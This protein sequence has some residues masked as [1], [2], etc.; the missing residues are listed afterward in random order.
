MRYAPRVRSHCLLSLGLLACSAPSA[1]ERPP[2][3]PAPEVTVAPT[4]ESL[5]VAAPDRPDVQLDY[6]FEIED[7]AAWAQLAARSREH[8][9]AR[10]DVVKVLWDHT[11]DRLWFCQSERWPIHYD[12]AV[13][14]IQTDERPLGD[15]SSFNRAQYLR[16]DRE[17]Q[18]ASLVRYRDAE[19]W[20]LELGP[21]DN[22]DGRSLVALH[23]RVSAHVFFGDVLHY[24]PRSELHRRRARRVRERVRAIEANR[25]WSGIT[26]QP[27]TLGEA[28]GRLRFVEGHLDPATVLPETILVLDHVPDDVPVCAGIVTAQ[29]QAPLAH[30]AV[31]SQ[32]RGTPNMALRGVMAGPLRAL[33]DQIVRIDVGADDYRLTPANAEALATSL[34]TRRPPPVAPPALDPSHEPLTPTCELRLADTAWAGAK[35]AQL[36]EV[37]AA[38]VPTSAGFVIP[39]HHYLSHLERHGIDASTET[40]RRADGFATDGRVRERVLGALRERIA[41]A[42]VDPALLAE[43]RARVR[44]A[45]GRRWI[46]R[47]STN[48]EDLPG[49]SGAGLYDSIVTSVDPDEAAIA[50][51]VQAVWASVFSRRAWDEREFYRLDH[52][53]V[54]MA[55]LVQPFLE[56]VVAMGVAITENPFSAQRSGMLVNLAPPGSSVTAARGEELPEQVLLYRHS[57]AEIISRST[58]NGGRPI[59]PAESMRPLRDRL[60]RVHTHMMALW[61]TRAD[62]ADVELALLADGSATILQ[63]RPYRMRRE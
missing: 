14:F 2:V 9:V 49:F 60:E 38:G 7:E 13:R 40:L 41:G 54:A 56:D 8:A 27:V 32:S 52:E 62:A 45:P 5:A 35:A 18:M 51:A 59:L 20:T 4:T 3:E 36:G 58:A 33:D 30:V 28:V 12:F 15:R 19:L 39:V 10:T 53:A 31:L 43:L 17:M 21:A 42:A 55:I 23:E 48:A 37:C 11:T 61:G 50:E 1:P 6:L 47:S 26:Y 25:V 46:F 29:I 22:L 34:A 24:R 16:P 63:A 44:R 57:R